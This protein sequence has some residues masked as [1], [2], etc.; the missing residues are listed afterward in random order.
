MPTSL[1]ETTRETSALD[2]DGGGEREGLSLPP[3][4]PGGLDRPPY[5][6]GKGRRKPAAA[7]DWGPRQG[8]RGNPGSIWPGETRRARRDSISSSW[9]CLAPAQLNGSRRTFSPFPPFCSRLFLLYSPFLPPSSPGPRGRGMGGQWGGDVGSRDLPVCPQ[10][11]RAGEG[12]REGRA[13]S[14]AAL[15][16]RH[17]RGRHLRGTAAGEGGRQG[18]QGGTGEKSIKRRGTTFHCHT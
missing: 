8:V 15:W 5:S 2:G 7:Q 16:P 1:S 9:C 13:D 4:P 11:G 17:L 18:G 10:G 6:L 12:G 14:P 3:S